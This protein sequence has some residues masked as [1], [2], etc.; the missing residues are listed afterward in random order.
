[1]PIPRIDH[2][3][4][5]AGTIHLGSTMGRV[6]RPKWPTTHPSGMD[7]AVGSHASVSFASVKFVFVSAIMKLSSEGRSRA[8]RWRG[9]LL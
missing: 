4:V 7:A 3:A 8:S 9:Q 6:K 1:M 5:P 2:S